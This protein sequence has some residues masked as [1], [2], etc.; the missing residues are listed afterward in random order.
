M[1]ARLLQKVESVYILVWMF[2]C[3]PGIETIFEDIRI[4][5]EVGDEDS[6][7]NYQLTITEEWNDFCI[8]QTT[9]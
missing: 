7:D 2:R 3:S 6:I 9:V 5:V 4:D 1:R 8:F